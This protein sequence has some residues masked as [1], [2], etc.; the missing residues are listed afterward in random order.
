LAAVCQTADYLRGDPEGDPSSVK[1]RRHKR[2]LPVFRRRV[3]IEFEEEVDG[4]GLLNFVRKPI[5]YKEVDGFRMPKP[6]EYVD[7]GS[8]RVRRP[9]EFVFFEDESE[10]GTRYAIRSAKQF[11][12]K[13]DPIVRREVG[14]QFAEVEEIDD[15]GVVRKIRHDG[16]ELY[17]SEDGDEIVTI[18]R[19]QLSEVLQ[20]FCVDGHLVKHKPEFESAGNDVKRRVPE[21][22]YRGEDDE[23]RRERRQFEC[24]N[25]ESDGGTVHRARRV[26]EQ[27]EI[28]H[29]DIDGEIVKRPKQLATVEVRDENDEIWVA[30][31]QVHDDD[32]EFI[33]ILDANND[34]R[35]VK[36]R[37][38]FAF[39][40]D[41]SKV[42]RTPVSKQEL[43]LVERIC[44]ENSQITTRVPLKF[45]F[46]EFEKGISVHYPKFA[47]EFNN[48]EQGDGQFVR[49]EKQFTCEF[50]DDAFCLRHEIEP[51][52]HEYDEIEDEAGDLQ[53]VKRKLKFE[54]RDNVK[55]IKRDDDEEYGFEDRDGGSLPVKNQFRFVEVQCDDD[56]VRKVRRIVCPTETELV[57]EDG[58]TIIAKPV[59]FQI[60]KW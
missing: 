25:M 39:V 19:E 21:F 2:P 37:K 10:S 38:Q 9:K 35:I 36:R 30:S 59:Q 14:K 23:I 26:V 29:D 44:D 57:T 32:Y 8:P 40:K 31:K 58:E 43:C 1:I 6:Y 54:T 49:R 51:E 12:Y 27:E 50:T 33:Q 46:V 41:Q 47:D 17:E 60:V 20:W 7:F 55:H 4:E 16:C 24:V 18:V 53:I 22:S 52:V 15:D 28:E 34:F 11:E 48:F 45:A 3:R 42:V 13:G 56:K 5:E